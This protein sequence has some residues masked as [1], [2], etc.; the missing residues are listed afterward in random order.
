MPKTLSPT[1]AL[2]AGA[3]RG[4]VLRRVRRHPAWVPELL[5]GLEDERPKVRYGCGRVLR[6]LA[7]DHP[8]KLKPYHRP[9]AERLQ[10]ENK[11]LR[12]DVATSLAAMAGVA[13]PA[14]TRELL[15]ELTRPLRGPELIP[16]ANAA[17]AL[18]ELAARKPLLLPEV[19]DALLASGR[20]RLPTAECK[21]VLAGSVVDAFTS[22]APLGAD[23][24][25]VLRY[26]RRQAKSERPGTRKRAERWLKRHG[27]GR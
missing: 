5:A 22:L 20:A 25:R 4:D 18:A 11:L 26:V 6:A 2:A 23:D 19:L 24:P 14:A 3:E 1:E 16:A 13:R 15:P 12:C 10:L 8:E 9:L 17:A 27:E 21:R 7:L